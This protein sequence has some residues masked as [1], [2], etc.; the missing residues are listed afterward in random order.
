[1]PPSENKPQRQNTT[2]SAGG[3]EVGQ[4]VWSDAELLAFFEES[5]PAAKM[6]KLEKACRHDQALRQRLARVRGREDA[7][8]HTVGA[9]WRRNRLSCPPRGELGQYLLRV[10]PAE[11]AEYIRF[12]LEIVGCRIC[13]ASVRDLE[14]QREAAS[15]ELQQRQ[16]RFFE[17]S[18][19]YLSKRQS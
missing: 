12:H 14:L 1:M 13:Q 10:L 18:A 19:G 4:E 5:L 9:I 3:S 8:L 16:S 11:Y 7:G 2:G 17:S 6:A 15:T